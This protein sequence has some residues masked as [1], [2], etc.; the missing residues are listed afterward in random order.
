MFITDI[1]RNALVQVETY[2]RDNPED[3]RSIAR[4]LEAFKFQ[5]SA[6]IQ[7]IEQPS[8]MDLEDL[9]DTDEV[10]PVMQLRVRH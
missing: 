2:E 4:C 5:I 10:E 8:A 6:M 1:L 3:A 9:A 7:Y